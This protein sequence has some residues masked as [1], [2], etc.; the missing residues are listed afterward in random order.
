MEIKVYFQTFSWAVCTQAR[1]AAAIWMKEKYA[2]FGDR[3][4]SSCFTENN[5][6]VTAWITVRDGEEK[7][8]EI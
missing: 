7:T 1:M 8:K 3:T 4:V 6:G 5:S 2:E